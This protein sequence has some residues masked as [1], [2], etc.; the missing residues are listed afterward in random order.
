[1]CKAAA[2]TVATLMSAI[3]PTLVN[4]LTLEGIAAT[5]EGQA[6][7]TAFNAALQAVENWKSGTSAQD[8]IQ[9]ID[10]FTQVFNTLPIPA[11]AKSLADIISAGIVTVIGVLTANSPAPA[12]TTSIVAHQEATAKT[13]QAK[14][15]ELVPGYRES[16]FAR[17]RAAL[18]DSGVAAGE[19]KK[20]WNEG[21]TKVGGKYLV[22]KTA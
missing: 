11:E 9:V 21:V 3:E 18:G 14:V 20:V 13:A 19:Y 16:W 10:A 7:I 4:L 12:A 22:L 1:M 2:S 6:A 8:V 17:S 15:Q 5:T